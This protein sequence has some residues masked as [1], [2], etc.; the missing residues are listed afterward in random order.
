MT[1]IRAPVD[2]LSALHASPAPFP[3]PDLPVSPVP[4][5]GAAPRF[6]GEPVWWL[7]IDAGAE[8]RALAT[9]ARRVHPDL[10]PGLPGDAAAAAALVEITPLPRFNAGLLGA[11]V[12]GAPVQYLLIAHADLAGI[13]MADDEVRVAA[14]DP[15]VHLTATAWLGFV[16]QDRICRDQHAWVDD[17]DA[18]AQAPGAGTDAG[19]TAF[20]DAVRQLVPAT[21]R[22]LDHVGR[23]APDGVVVVTPTGGAAQTIT[24]TPAT[25][26]DTQVQ[27]GAAGAEI[28]PAPGNPSLLLSSVD[29]S[30]GSLGG[31]LALTAGDRQVCQLRLDGWLA[32]RTA[33][34][35]GLSRWTTGNTVEPIVDG[36]AYFARLVPD[37][38]SAKAGGAVG[39][40]GW[41]FV[42]EGLLDPSKPWSLLPGD[43]STE[44]VAL[45]DELVTGGA[46]VRI[47]ANQFLQITDADL[48]A[49]RDDVVVALVAALILLMPFSALG[50]VWLN[51]IGWVAAGVAPGVVA[52]LPDAALRALLTSIVELSKSTVEAVNAQ[53]PSTAVFTPYPA[54]LADNPLAENP[55]H[56]ALVPV[57]ALTHVGVYHQKI[58]V[59]R[60]AAG[61]L[62]AYV[63]GIDINSDRL[64]DPAHRALAPFHDVQV[65][66]T[67]PAV[68]EVVATFV[69]RAG[70][71][72]ASSPVA[73]PAAA[74]PATGDQIVQ[75]GRTYFAPST[76]AGH[77]TPFPSAPMGDGTTRATVLAAIASARDF[78][79]I[80]DQYL[81][82]DQ[83]Y[84]D[85]LLAAA[86]PARG[87]RALVITV[88]E[89][90]DQPYGALR[91]GDIVH[92][93]AAAWG[94]RL[95]V[96]APTR[97]YVNPS[98]YVFAGLGRM[99]LRLDMSTGDTEAVFG[100]AD[101][102]PA[103][104]FWA[105]VD[106]ELM[107]VDTVALGGTGTGPIGTQDPDDPD[108]ADQTWR[109][110][111]VQRGPLAGSPRWGASVTDHD[112]G[113]P[114]LAVQLRGIYV[115]AK[116]MIVDDVFVSVGSSNLNRRGLDHD[117]EINS[118]SV[119][120][121]QKRD[122]ANPALRLRCRLWAEHF[123][124]PPE[125]GLSLL[126]DPLS[127]VQ[128]FDRSWYRGSHWQ[129][130]SFASAADPPVV[131]LPTGDSVRS[132]ILGLTTG[133]VVAAEQQP[134]WATLVDP[135]T[136][137]DSHVDPTMDRGPHL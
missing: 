67:G 132:L 73:V 43:D 26:G 8:L 92:A 37:L 74:P 49:L 41:A 102:L 78:I 45:V 24:L 66:V 120:L 86:D 28:A 56:V 82:P 60:R 81:T 7:R 59:I 96:G 111:S 9:G 108:P 36:N 10:R 68:A 1:G 11:L 88:P 52:M 18:A 135:T 63:G 101:R 91:R 103:V 119:P 85:A 98:P 27:V 87:V 58:V 121:S 2:P 64:D 93:L 55:L 25:H 6:A 50:T 113:A 70:T 133:I 15:V 109:R 125:L 129:P 30:R 80:E 42:K 99:V 72:G 14:G 29:T 117:G 75:I 48:A 65:R 22:V 71:V 16:R 57:P 131:A 84:V 118:F 128:F 134:F 5:P 3:V 38:R 122:P 107:Y 12:G 47:L 105:F 33:G 13:S 31:T 115:H 19:W 104:P 53:H 76:A 90:A 79:Y 39:L 35:T 126:A 110:V 77:G 4:P 32:P 112:K 69:E 97:R 21:V 100:P 61:D 127:A 46:D 94:N 51:P 137:L 23:P 83:D 54:T 17:L 116:L 130:F 44:L 95:R 34:V 123:G 20:R 62:V 40:A 106:S 136:A 114:V 89:R 124:L